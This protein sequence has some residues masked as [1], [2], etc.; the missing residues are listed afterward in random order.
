MFNE[1]ELNF[2]IK[3][4]DSH[5]GDCWSMEECC[6]NETLEQIGVWKHLEFYKEVKNKLEKKNFSFTE[7]EAKFLANYCADMGE[8]Y[9]LNGWG[10]E[11]WFYSLANK[12]RKAVAYDNTKLS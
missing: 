3:Y 12:I 10:D 4:C 5:I 6:S 7:R 11:D 1:E 8:K 9:E 2:L